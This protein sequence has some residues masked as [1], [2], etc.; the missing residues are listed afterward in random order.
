M[1]NIY[2]APEISVQDV[3]RKRADGDDFVLIDVREQMELIR[4]NLGDGVEWVPLSKLAAQRLAALPDSMSDKDTEIVVFC[5]TGVRSAQ[6]TAWLL[7]E[8][9]RNVWSMGGGI[10]A[11]AK[12]VDASVGIY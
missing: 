9:W 7:H 4:A 1:A 11:Y 2:G 5:H 3:A 6:V 8:G 12:E 10:D